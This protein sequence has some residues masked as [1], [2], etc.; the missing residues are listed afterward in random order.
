MVKTAK[1]APVS[2]QNTT[3][4]RHSEKIVWILRGSYRWN[5][6]ELSVADDT[7]LLVIRPV[8]GDA[9]S[10]NVSS[11][12]VLSLHKLLTDWLPFDNPHH[13]LGHA[14]ATRAAH[15]QV[16]DFRFAAHGL[17]LTKRSALRMAVK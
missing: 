15:F 6:F 8:D 7:T 13:C 12:Q 17:L 10:R 16:L 14:R 9:A 11:V 3:N 2:S 4:H 5:H 1:R